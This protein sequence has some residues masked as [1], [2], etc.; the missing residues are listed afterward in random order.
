MIPDISVVIPCFNSGETLAETV[1]SVLEQTWRNFE[2]LVVNSSSSDNTSSIL[3]S[4]EDPRLKVINAPPGNVAR[5]R[6]RGLA[7]ACARFI[8][9]LDADDLWSK[10]KL[11]AQYQALKAN[12]DAHVCYSWTDCIDEQGRLLFPASHASWE[13]HVCEKLLLSNFVASGSNFMAYTDVV[14]EMEGFD[15]SLS[16]CQ[17]FDICIRLSEKYKFVAVK[18]CQIFYRLRDN[19]MSRDLLGL[20]QSKNRILEAFFDRHP[21]QSLNHTKSKSYSNFYLF[22]SLKALA[23]PYS[24]PHLSLRYLSRSLRWRPYILFCLDSY[25]IVARA[26]FGLIVGERLNTAFVTRMKHQRGKKRIS[27][28]PSVASLD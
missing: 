2:L 16:N 18:R 20:E 17:D 25:K 15:E 24:Q 1:S 21:E 5:N 27:I 11:E 19:S 10:D 6:N 23:V 8:T 14:R 13:G 28:S 9:F 12:P 22:L 3:A 26:I 4:F 7:V